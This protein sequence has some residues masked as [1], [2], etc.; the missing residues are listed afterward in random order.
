[1]ANW[2]IMA[3]SGKTERECMQSLALHVSYGYEP[4]DGL[5]C[6]IKGRRFWHN[7]RKSAQRIEDEKEVL[8]IPATNYIYT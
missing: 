5:Y 7:V 2:E 1:M 6:E 4:V 8:E 3:V